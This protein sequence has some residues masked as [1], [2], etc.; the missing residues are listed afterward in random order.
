MV[1]VIIPS[2]NREKT[3]ARAVNS[4]LNQTF[5]DIEVIVVDDCSTDNTELV[6][7][8]IPDKR[9]HYYKLKKNSGACVARNKGIELANGE[10]IAFQDSDDEWH[11]DKLAS[12]M[13]F[14][15][16]TGADIVFCSYR[17]VDDRKSSDVPYLEKSHLCDQHELAMQPKVSTQTILAKKEV[18]E[19]V[20][21]DPDMPRMQDYEFILRAIEHFV[22]WY[23]GDSLVNV[24]AQED[25]ITASAK[26]YQKREEVTKLLL[27]KHP[28]WANR[29]PDWKEKM[30]ATL[31]HCRVMLNRDCNE[32]LDE[33]CTM[34]PSVNNKVK[35]VLY[36]THILKC[37]FEI[38]DDFR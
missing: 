21:F 27:E 35:R 18:F 29:Y 3:I 33:I 12:Q 10:F 16:E 20:C 5:S 8:Q 9:V 11:R 38:R 13:I 26:Q 28:E 14:L 25:S 1:S 32:L 15:K 30:Y 2:Y 31:L 36:H 17:K 19:K 34:N 4:V 6:V 24:Y 22:I 37:L 23:Q 7:K